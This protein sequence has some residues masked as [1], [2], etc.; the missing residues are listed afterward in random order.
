MKN[1]KSEATESEFKLSRHFCENWYR[2]VGNWPDVEAVKHYIAESVEVQHCKDL[3]E[4]DGRP[5]RILAIYYHPE[6]E[7]VMMIDHISD[8]AVTVLNRKCLEERGKSG[9]FTCQG[10]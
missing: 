9:R 6:L 4:V 5:C 7:L 2:R 3:L 1:L 10:D 8:T